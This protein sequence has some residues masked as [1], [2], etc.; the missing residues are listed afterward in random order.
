MKALASY[1]VWGERIF[2][3]IGVQQLALNN[4]HLSM[5]YLMYRR[6]WALGARDV[7]STP[8]K[9]ISL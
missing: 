8:A 5:H 3:F 9:I 7:R 4:T 2:T 6:H 1:Y